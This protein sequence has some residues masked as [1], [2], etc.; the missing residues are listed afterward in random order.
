M[1]AVHAF[2][3]FYQYNQKWELTMGNKEPSQRSASAIYSADISQFEKQNRGIV[4]L[5]NLQFS[6]PNLQV[7]VTKLFTNFL[8][9]FGLNESDISFSKFSYSTPSFLFQ[10]SSLFQLK[11]ALS[12][13]V[14]VTMPI[15]E[16]TANFSATFSN[17]ICSFKLQSDYTLEFEHLEMLPLSNVT[18]DGC[19]YTSKMKL[20]ARN[21]QGLFNFCPLDDSFTVV[22]T[23]LLVKDF[24]SPKLKHDVLL[25]VLKI[26]PEKCSFYSG[27]TIINCNCVHIR[28]ETAFFENVIVK[29]EENNFPLTCIKEAHSEYELLFDY[30]SFK[31]PLQSILI[32]MKDEIKACIELEL[33]KHVN[34]DLEDFP[35][36]KTWIPTLT[37]LPH[38]LKTVYHTNS[39][40]S[41]DSKKTF[42]KIEGEMKSSP[43]SVSLQF[44][45][46]IVLTYTALIH[47]FLFY[48]PFSVNVHVTIDRM[49]GKVT[50]ACFDKKQYT[51]STVMG[52]LNGRYLRITRFIDC[53]IQPSVNHDPMTL[54]DIL[55]G[56]FRL[57]VQKESK[58]RHLLP[59]FIQFQTSNITHISLH[60]VTLVLRATL[61]LENE[62]VVHIEYD[63]YS[64][65]GRLKIDTEELELM[66]TAIPKSL[67]LKNGFA[68]QQLLSHLTNVTILFRE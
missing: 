53:Y 14:T 17:I 22:Q 24:L 1:D 54:E 60:I 52:S 26:L 8:L 61:E 7:F 40:M 46:T 45:N 2:S 34:I 15:K 3:L 67:F 35:S 56:P 30:N 11:C 10:F 63:Y 49:T 29:V 32:L 44:S 42:V 5:S 39:F 33:N 59:L 20:N 58:I 51:L 13:P 27:K 43:S 47:H 37:N 21:E 68:K 28:R 48:T 36:I 18:F 6:Q 31:S 66:C 65:F 57:S 23:P 62:N 64:N 19:S 38:L 55:K 4:A 16:R 25:S 41:Y 12:K 9:H 50:S